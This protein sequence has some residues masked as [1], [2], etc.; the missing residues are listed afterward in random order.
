MPVSHWMMLGLAP[1]G[2]YNQHDFKLT[3]G[4]PTQQAKK[5]AD[6]DQIKERIKEKKI[7]GLARLWAVKAVRTFSDGSRGYFWYT[8]NASDY[9]AAYEYTFGQRKA[10]MLFI[11]QVFNVANLFLLL[12]SSL[13]FFRT[14]K[15][16]INLL[17]QICLFGSFL[18]FVFLWEA[19]PR[20]ALLFTPF[21]ISRGSL[22]A[23]RVEPRL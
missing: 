16:D 15:Y 22:W 18:F 14:K 9:S 20:Y 10:L 7:N 13:R 23:G 5:Q 6:F 1:N 8:K 3:L 17:M 11:I 19:E 2:R 21:M 4:Q 12:L